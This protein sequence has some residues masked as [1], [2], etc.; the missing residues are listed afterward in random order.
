MT[1]TTRREDY[2]G[3]PSALVTGAVVLFLI[4]PQLILLWQSFTAEPHLSFP[5]AAYG[6]RWYR[7]VLTSP[8]WTQAIARSLLVAGIVTPLTL[9]IG[10]AAA[11][12]L[13]RGPL[14]GRR[15]LYTTLISPMILPHVVLGLAMFRVA[16]W[17]DVQ[18]TV[19]GYVLAHLTISVPYVVITVGASLQSFDRSLEEAAQ[20]LGAS[21]WRALCHITLPVIRPGIVAGGIFTFITSLDEFIITYFLSTHKVTL[22][23]QVFSSLTYQLEPSISAVSGLTLMITGLLTGLLVARGQIL[24][25][26]RIVR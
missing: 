17:F 15:A 21:P 22:P 23:I 8:D 7:Y 12:G 11:L 20:S 16:L 10:A 19:L 13:D 6:L 3:R 25:G 18:D 2:R 14:R 24:G 5:P 1:P 4:A 26:Q 9:L